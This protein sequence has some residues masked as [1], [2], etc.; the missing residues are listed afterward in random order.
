ML[1]HTSRPAFT[2]L[3]EGASAD[4]SPADGRASTCPGDLRPSTLPVTGRLSGPLTGCIDTPSINLGVRC[5][6]GANLWV[7][8]TLRAVSQEG[9]LLISSVSHWRPG[10]LTK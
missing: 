6:D 2:E 4:G 10:L 9:L 5:V 1:G 7:T 3:L 8:S